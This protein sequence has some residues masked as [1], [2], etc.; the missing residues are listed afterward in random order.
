MNDTLT[1]Q[2]TVTFAAMACGECGIEFYVPEWFKK[3]RRESGTVWYCPN[4]HNRVYKERESEQ[5]RR[6]LEAKL[7]R[8]AARAS[9]ALS[10]LDQ[11]R[12]SHSATK[13]QLTKA[14]KRAANGVCPCCQ[15]S[16]V[17]VARHVRSKHPAFA[18]DPAAS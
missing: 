12:A 11:E 14:K 6:D 5:V 13:G 2:T 9:S 17:D 3:E 18:A 1:R 4:G 16:F 7:Q 8:E 15:R 10:R